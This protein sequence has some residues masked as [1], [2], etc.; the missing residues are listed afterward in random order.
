MRR[1]GLSLTNG[2]CGVRRLRG[3]NATRRP[4]NSR[5]LMAGVV[6]GEMEG[7]WRA[8]SGRAARVARL[9][10]AW[11]RLFGSV[12]NR[13]RLVSDGLSLRR[14]RVVPDAVRLV[15]VGASFRGGKGGRKVHRFS[16]K[17]EGFLSK[18]EAF[19]REGRGF[20]PKVH[21]FWTTGA[22]SWSAGRP[23]SRGA[24]AIVE[25]RADYRW[26]RGWL[27]R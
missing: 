8:R 16:S 5:V 14:R 18:V 9:S 21:N 27:I 15:A 12:H 19:C 17:T 24:G 6:C 25:R 26:S 1:R 10:T 23:S 2:R 11:L 4:S 3:E 20:V 13:C 7:E 22:A